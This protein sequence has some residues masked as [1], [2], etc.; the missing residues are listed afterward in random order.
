MCGTWGDVICS[1]GYFQKSFPHGGK[2]IYYGGVKHVPEFLHSQSF[3][4][5]VINVRPRNSVDYYAV[6][7]LL[8]S[9]DTVDLGVERII[10]GTR[11]PKANVVSTSVSFDYPGQYETD[12]PIARNL[13][14]PSDID[15]WSRDFASSLNRPYYVVQPYSI[16]TVSER[17]HYPYWNDILEWIARDKSKHFVL[18]GK[19]WNAVPY[20]GF[21]NVTNLVNQTPTMSHVFALSSHAAGV[22]TTSNSLAHWCVSQ[23]LDTVCVAT[24]RSSEPTHFFNRV[25][26]GENF[27]LFTYY[28]KVM[29]ILFHLRERWA[30]WPTFVDTR[31]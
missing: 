4:T 5:E 29:P 25:L 12:M 11:I 10:A 9:P 26:Q 2:V 1:L 30:V 14:V 6:V 19:D 22:I 31:Y 18:V 24:M 17:N 23:N 16:N 20:E 3:L 8:W 7:D 15:N 21:E 28:N 13:S 27:K